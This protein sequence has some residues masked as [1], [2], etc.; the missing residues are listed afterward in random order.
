MEHHN[1]QKQ[2]AMT[3][4]QRKDIMRQASRTAMSRYDDAERQAAFAQGYGQCDW[5]YQLEH[6]LMKNYRERYKK[7]G[8]SEWF[9]KHYEGKSLGDCTNCG[10]CS[11]DVVNGEKNTVSTPRYT[12]F[13]I[14]NRLYHLIDNE[15]IFPPGED[16]GSAYKLL[17]KFLDSLE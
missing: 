8:E 3:L 15:T 2:I 7:L 6:I 4:E 14:E 12:K 5:L 17:N 1:R 11:E 9:K 10:M 16:M 13:E